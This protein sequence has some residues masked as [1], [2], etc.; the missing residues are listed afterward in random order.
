MIVRFKVAVLASSCL[1]AL[2]QWTYV[3]TEGVARIQCEVT[4]PASDPGVQLSQANHWIA[5]VAPS[6][7]CERTVYPAV[8]SL[9]TCSSSSQARRVMS[10]AYQIQ[11]VVV[12]AYTSIADF[13]ENLQ[14]SY[15][16]S[17]VLA[18]GMDPEVEYVRVSLVTAAAGR[19][20]RLLEAL[21]GIE[22][23]TTVSFDSNEEAI[24]AAD[25]LTLERLQAACASYHLNDVRSMSKPRFVGDTQHSAETS[26]LVGGL[27]GGGILLFVA[28]AGLT[29]YMMQRGR[30]ESRED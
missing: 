4:I 27:I 9:T 28:L 19:R 15:R 12:L 29:C 23:T 11:F 24:A 20:R 3:C 30:K 17:V 10:T 22:V 18:L 16:K 6:A 7:R 25:Y 5:N 26:F 2:Q 14:L 13:T 1:A 8:L 21:Q